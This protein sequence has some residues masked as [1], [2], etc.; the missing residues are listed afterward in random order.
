MNPAAAA[1]GF[2]FARMKCRRECQAC[3][4]RPG[5]VIKALLRSAARGNGL[6]A[7]FDWNRSFTTPMMMSQ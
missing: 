6:P 3:E 7:F 2:I 1:A 4:A 5:R